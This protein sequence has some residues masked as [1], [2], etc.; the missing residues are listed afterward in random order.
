MDGRRPVGHRWFVA[1]D[2]TRRRATQIARCQAANLSQ[3]ITDRVANGL[4]VTDSNGSILYV[5]RSGLRML[6]YEANELV[7]RDSRTILPHSRPDGT[8]SRVEDCQLASLHSTSATNETVEERFWRKDGSKLAVACSSSPVLLASGVGSVVAFR[9]VSAERA[10][11][12]RS[13]A[14]HQTLIANLPDISVFLL[15]HDLRVL[16]AEGEASRRL[17]WFSEDMFRGRKVSELYADIPGH[18]LDLS[19]EHYRAA[20]RGER[21]AFEFDSDGLTFAVQAVPVHAED[22]SVE[23]ALVVSSD[24]TERAQAARRIARHAVQHNAVAELSRFALESRAVSMLMTVAVACA[25]TTL[26]LDVAGVVEVGADETVTH[27][28]AIGLPAQ[29]AA[30]Q[31]VSP[32]ETPIAEHVLRTGQP[33]IIEDMATETRFTSA[34]QLL[35]HGVV[36]SMAVAIDGHDGPFGI[37]YVHA[38]ESRAFS[39]DEVAFLTAVAA[40]IT[41]AVERHRDEQATRHAALHD[42]LTRLPNR[43]LAFDR[44]EQALAHRRREGIDVAVF[45]LDIDRFKTINDAL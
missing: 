10:S 38:R 13:D 9:D 16:V 39:D 30:A 36:S 26:G 11:F 37:L 25:T 22:G 8:P 29:L 31:R 43:A 4:Y 35:E 19:L 15:D 5:N 2:V 6:G 23:S 41:V 27:L 45:A 24:V 20:L 34:P 12:R 44:L 32:T 18:L 42:P 33:V 7:G 17:P 21:R 40:L 14:L 3:A 28:A 1:K